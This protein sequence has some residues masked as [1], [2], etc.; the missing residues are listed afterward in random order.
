VIQARFQLD[1]YTVRLLDVIKGKFGLKNRD[2]A[3]NKLALEVGEKYVEPIVNE[4]TLK[5]LDLIYVNHM[6]KHANRK[7]TDKELK[8][9][10]NV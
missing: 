6:N 10:L 1:E 8:G 7:M 9:L 2:E 3:L 4:T 5:E